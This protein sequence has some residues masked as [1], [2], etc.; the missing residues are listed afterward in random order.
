MHVYLKNFDIKYVNI[1]YIYHYS[2]M[3]LWLV[4]WTDCGRSLQVNLGLK[5]WCARIVLVGVSSLTNGVQPGHAWPMVSRDLWSRPEV[6]PSQ[7]NSPLYTYLRQDTYSIKLWMWYTLW[8]LSKGTQ[9]RRKK[10]KDICLRRVDQSTGPASKRVLGF[11]GCL[12]LAC[13]LIN[14]EMRH[15]LPIILYMCFKAGPPYFWGI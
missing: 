15:M 2:T 12:G 5:T 6:S 4:F 10:S 11:T 7:K 13:Y 3:T 9:L 8:K 1:L 14:S